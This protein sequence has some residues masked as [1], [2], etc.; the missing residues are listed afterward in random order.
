MAT[1]KQTPL[2]D[3]VAA[4]GNLYEKTNKSVD[5]IDKHLGIDTSNIF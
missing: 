2:T 3:E 4:T 1:Q 5:K